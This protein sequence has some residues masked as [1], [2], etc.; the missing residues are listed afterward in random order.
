MIERDDKCKYCYHNTA[1]SCYEDPK[2]CEDYELNHLAEKY[3]G[4]RFKAKWE[5]GNDV[6]VIVT[7]E[8]D[9][10][11]TWIIETVEDAEE[12][13]DFMNKLWMESQDIEDRF[14]NAILELLEKYFIQK[15][16]QDTLVLGDMFEEKI[17]VL[18]ELLHEVGKEHLI[19]DFYERIAEEIPD[20]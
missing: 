7:D 19:V 8:L 12:L 11:P 14:C 5:D 9:E 10:F 2:E 16:S 3:D 15:H 13:A 6:Q 18:E 1:R 17:N 20:E 4:K